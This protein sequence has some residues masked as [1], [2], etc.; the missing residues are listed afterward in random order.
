MVLAELFERVLGEPALPRVW[1]ASA[2]VRAGFRG[3]RRVGFGLIAVS[4][5]PEELAAKFTLPL[6]FDTPVDPKLP[7]INRWL[8]GFFK[9]PVP[10]SVFFIDGKTIRWLGD[11]NVLLFF[12]NSGFDLVFY[13]DLLVLV[14]GV[15]I[16]ISMTGYVH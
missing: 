4:E 3:A 14:V 2:D 7:G 5:S 6:V 8:D 12:W 13:V 11:T 1:E 16:C 10:P 15:V 9:M